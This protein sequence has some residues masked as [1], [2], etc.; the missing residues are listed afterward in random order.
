MS[1]SSSSQRTHGHLNLTNGT[2]VKHMT[3][4]QLEAI[5][6]KRQKE[7]VKKQ[8]EVI[9]CEDKLLDL[10]D[11]VSNIT[12]TLKNKRSHE[13]DMRVSTTRVLSHTKALDIDRSKRPADRD[14]EVRSYS[15]MDADIWRYDQVRNWFNSYATDQ[16][17]YKFVPSQT[18]YTIKVD[19]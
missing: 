7:I 5:R 4:E 12:V 19:D 13:K 18:G 8:S 15:K 16:E 3:P 11:T 9:K 17:P 1:N 2:L 14:F 6:R 10:K